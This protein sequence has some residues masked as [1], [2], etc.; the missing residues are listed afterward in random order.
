MTSR[1]AGSMAAKL[2]RT[3]EVA[4]VGDGPV[5]Q[6]VLDTLAAAGLEDV[7]VVLGDDA[8]AIEAAI[9]WRGERRV[10]N[11][12]PA[13]GLSSSLRIGATAVASDAPAVLVVLGDQPLVP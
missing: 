13:L 4:G 9:E 11:P 8:P 1:E 10:R 2:R 3:F 7:V 6:H 5:L 12:E